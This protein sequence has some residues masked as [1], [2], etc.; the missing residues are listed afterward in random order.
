VVVR[1]RKV[2]T[3]WEVA[4][5]RGT[6]VFYKEVDAKRLA[7]LVLKGAKSKRRRKI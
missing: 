5:D 7:K 2:E 6:F 4:C 3:W 1:V